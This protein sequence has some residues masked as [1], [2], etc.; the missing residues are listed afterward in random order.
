MLSLKMFVGIKPL[1]V[2]W[3]FGSMSTKMRKE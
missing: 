1:Y 2:V 3:D